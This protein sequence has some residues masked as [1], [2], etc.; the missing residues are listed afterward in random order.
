ETAIRRSGQVCSIPSPGSEL[1]M[2]EPRSATVFYDEEDAYFG[3]C[4]ECGHALCI[5]VGRMHWM[6]C[7]QH[8]VCWWVGENLFSSWKYQNLEEQMESLEE[9]KGCMVIE[10][11]K[12]AGLFDVEEAIRVIE[13]LFAKRSAQ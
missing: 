8:K 1:M 13:E 6:Y 7:P 12:P 10:D 11:S 2:P 3:A 9:L 5:N 4:S